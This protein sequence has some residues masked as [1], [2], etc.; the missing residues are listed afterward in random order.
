MR[1]RT[2]TWRAGVLA[3]S[4]IVRRCSDRLAGARAGMYLT[5]ADTGVKQVVVHGPPGTSRFLSAG[6]A[7]CENRPDAQLSSDE[8]K[9]ESPDAFTDGNV[10]IQP[11]VAWPETDDDGPSQ[12][13]NGGGQG[14]EDGRGGGEEEEEEEEEMEEEADAVRKN[15]R[16]KQP[17]RDSAVSYVMR[18]PDV[19][20]KFDVN[21]AKALGMRQTLHPKTMNNQP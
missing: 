8:M 20:G 13:T 14:Q 5:L 21:K 3:C 1:F 18:F 17:R 10:S 4:S 16:H 19:P 9:L 2:F 7:F 11:Y 15:V 12:A 6:Q